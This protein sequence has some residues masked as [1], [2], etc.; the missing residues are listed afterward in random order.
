MKPKS[1]LRDRIYRALVVTAAIALCPIWIPLLM[2]WLVFYVLASI[3]IYL[4]IWLFWLPRGTHILFVYSDSPIWH[5]YIEEHILPMIHDHA[6]VLNWSQRRSRSWRCSLAVA[7]FKHFGGW[8]GFNPMAVVF[9]PFKR[10]RVFRFLQPFRD[11]K[12]GKPEKLLAI[13]KEF[14]DY[15]QLHATQP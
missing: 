10:A 14:L 12:H 1:K 15:S 13:Q 5:D 6:V 4:V 2:L 3:C 7:A 9:R 11:L 8:R